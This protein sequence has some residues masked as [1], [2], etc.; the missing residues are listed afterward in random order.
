MSDKPNVSPEAYDIRLPNNIYKLRCVSAES[1]KSSGGHL[2]DVL[3]LEVIEAAPVNGA[4][5]PVDINGLQFTSYNT[6]SAKSIKFYN[7]MRTAFN[8]PPITEGEVDSVSFKQ[9]LGQVA[10]V[11]AGSKEEVRK[12][13]VTGEVLINPHT[14][15]PLVNLTREI[16]Q[17]IPCPNPGS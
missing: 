13:D 1:R 8:L 3:K 6:R 15:E 11:E 16:F 17:W 14:K 4:N 10:F 9:Y 5:G 12:N 7:K 2:Q